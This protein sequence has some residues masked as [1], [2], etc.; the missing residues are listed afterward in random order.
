[1]ALWKFR[2]G[3]VFDPDDALSVWICTLAV[4]LNDVV[5]TN[6]KV[7]GAGQPWERLY[8]WRVATGHFNE[9]CLHLERGQ[10]IQRV[11]QFV[12]SESDLSEKHADVLRRYGSSGL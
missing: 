5:H 8:E 4:A 12:E 2:V 10:E 3:A 7:E 9:A 1:M 11:S 6:V